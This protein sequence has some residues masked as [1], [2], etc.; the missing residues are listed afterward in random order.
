MRVVPD[1]VVQP[2]SQPFWDAAAEGRFLLKRCTACGKP[3]WY[4]R[5]LCPFCFGPTAWQPASGK[6]TLYSFSYMRKAA[7]PYVLAYVT[8][9]EG[10]TMM[11][12]IVDAD[13][14]MLRIGM[15]LELRFESSAG[16]FAVP[17][18]RPA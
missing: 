10:P 4:P 12:N 18:F 2:E 1:P 11:T 7:P 5:T 14:A 13:P 8:L 6:G 15:P 9:A 17:M 16:G 3:H